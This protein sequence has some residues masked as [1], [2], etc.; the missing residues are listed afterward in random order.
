M[1][2]LGD[3]LVDVHTERRSSQRRNSLKRVSSN[4]SLS[5]PAGSSEI[6]QVAGKEVMKPTFSSPPHGRKEVKLLPRSSL[7]GHLVPRGERKARKKTAKSKKKRAKKLTLLRSKMLTRPVLSR[8]EYQNSD[9][10]SGDSLRDLDVASDDERGG[11]DRRHEYAGRLPYR[12]ASGRMHIVR[13]QSAGRRPPS[14]IKQRIRPATA[15]KARMSKL[16]GG[17]GGRSPIGSLPIS[18]LGHTS[19][20]SYL[21]R[22][23][24][25][26]GSDQSDIVKN[27]GSV[28]VNHT[29]S[30]FV[31]MLALFYDPSDHTKIVEK[32]CEDALKLQDKMQLREYTG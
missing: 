9:P 4:S 27:S 7:T 29:Y 20:H 26:S 13:A 3:R 5:A 32:A 12:G 24:R 8:Q 30:D 11:R 14:A 21:A 10:E 23:S 19:G 18:Q 16:H 22:S 2:N 6:G 31:R 15:T 17:G 28:S 1:N 25:M